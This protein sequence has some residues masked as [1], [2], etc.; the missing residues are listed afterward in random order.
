MST[1]MPP[2]SKRKRVGEIVDSVKRRIRSLSK[3]EP[4]PIL[5]PDYNFTDRPRTRSTTVQLR[6][7]E[8]ARRKR[9]PLQQIRPEPEEESEEDEDLDLYRDPSPLPE[10]AQSQ[11]RLPDPVPAYQEWRDDGWPE[12]LRDD[13]EWSDTEP[14]HEE[15][16]NRIP[17]PGPAYSAAE[18]YLPGRSNPSSF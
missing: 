1:K 5:T 18:L 8:D 6:K 4:K 3:S 17:P 16:P 14:E 15:W 12:P 9:A 2:K 11:E 7:E 10:Y 13:Q